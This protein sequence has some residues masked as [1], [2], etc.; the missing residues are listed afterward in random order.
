MNWCL[1][2]L[3]NFVNKII[4]RNTNSNQA[5][6]LITSSVNISAQ[7]T[8]LVNAGEREKQ[9]ID[10]L[11]FFITKSEFTKIVVCD[12]SGYRYPAN[13]YDS[14][15]AN[16]KQLELLSFSGNNL[17]VSTYGKGYGEGE[18]IEYAVKH[19]ELLKGIQGFF[20]VTGRLKVSNV[21]N[22]IN[23][24]DLK[25]NYFM[26]MSLRPM[27]LRPAIIK[28][29]FDTRFYYTTKWLY[30]KYLRQ[31]YQQSDDSKGMYLEKVY[32]NSITSAGVKTAW[33]RPIPVIEGISG[34]TGKAYYIV[35][36][37][38]RRFINMLLFIKNILT[39]SRA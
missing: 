5:L 6:L 12:N 23:S 11:L 28:D 9:Y 19:S 38:K 10:S 39:P 20:K 14:S 7:F 26:P 37:V 21:N 13:I 3:L 33:F 34:S 17:L 16:N 27:F 1:T 24:V 32:Y 8:V 4:V 25:K 22:I 31:V 36:P 2:A 35:P 29:S 30:E 15:L 18:I